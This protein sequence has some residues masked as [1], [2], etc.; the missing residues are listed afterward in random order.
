MVSK[1]LFQRIP[2]SHPNSSSPFPKDLI[3]NFSLRFFLKFT[4]FFCRLLRYKDIFHFYNNGGFSLKSNYFF[5]TIVL[6]FCFGAFFACG[7]NSNLDEDKTPL[8][9]QGVLEGIVVKPSTVPHYYEAIGTIRAKTKA[10][11]SSKIAGQIKQ[12]DVIEG[13]EVE[14]GDLLL[15]IDD[16]EVIEKLKQAESVFVSTEK[17]LD[18]IQAAINQAEAQ[19]KEAE[20]NFSLAQTSYSRYENLSSQKIISI[21]EFDSIKAKQQMAEAQLNAAQE[22]V[23]RL[24]SQ[25]EGLAVSLARAQS[26]IKE[27]EV[28]KS[29]TK[30]TAP[31]TGII[32][33][34]YVD[35]GGFAVPGIPLLEIEDPQGFRLEVDVREAEFAN[36][37]EIGR[38]V[39]VQID[40]LGETLIIGTVVEAAPSAD[41]LSRSFRVKVALPKHQG[42]KSGMYGKA[43]C[44]RE[45]R[46]TI[47]IPKTALIERGQLEQV[48]SVDESQTAHLRLV[49]T[50]KAFGDSLEILAGLQSGDIII[51]NPKP[52]LKD[53][54]R[55]TVEI[56]Q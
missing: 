28:L 19:Q 42:I 14:A 36:Q 9:F 4:P 46:Q 20:V 23:S 8:I 25:K 13:S 27:A 32:I 53:R 30:I 49:K 17:A 50:G 37:V 31:F 6:M 7:H 51:T 35:V 3:N 12:I 44:P 43:L 29:H 5:K 33:K 38:E 56:K 16:R 54:S 10:A 34:K 21:Q 2:L 41:S 18:E 40:A 24:K 52:G 1:A 15:V 39:P 47:I 22:G 26:G 48:F 11:L 45:E 55:V